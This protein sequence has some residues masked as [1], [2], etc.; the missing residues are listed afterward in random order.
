MREAVPYAQETSFIG[1]PYLP[2]ETE[3]ARDIVLR[4]ERVSL[5]Y[6]LPNE[7][8]SS[9]KEYA[10]RRLQGR[11]RWVDVSALRDIE[12]TVRRGDVLGIIGRNG[13]GKS[14]LLRLVAGVLRP[15]SGRVWLKGWP[16]SPLLEIGAGFHTDLTGRENVYLNATL[17]GHPK[18]VI[19]KRFNE[20]VR[21]AELAEVIDAPLRTYSTGMMM[22]L[23]FA[24]ATAW[25]PTILLVDEVLAVGDEAFQV[26]CGAR[27]N[28]FRERGVTVLLVSHDLSLVRTLCSRAIWLDAGSIRAAGSPDEVADLYHTA[29]TAGAVADSL[30]AGTR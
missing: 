13:S 26:K 1:A 2:G 9:F 15:T 22:R 7:R 5:R 25:D 8:L 18:K 10:I 4:L 21:F 12:L 11:V 3:R 23:G 17:L 28:S 29:V 6:R 24:V 30:D 14:S 27:I 16:V 20:I 19:D